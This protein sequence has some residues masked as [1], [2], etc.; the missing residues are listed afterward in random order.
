METLFTGQNHIKIAQCDSVNTYAIDLI[1]NLELPEGTLISAN[2]QSNGKGQGTNKWYSEPGMNVTSSIIYKPKF[3]ELEN[4]FLL[5]MTVSLGLHDLVTCLLD[6]KHDIK[7]K[8]PNDI[9]VNDKKISGILIENLIRADSVIN[10]VI[11]IG[12]NVNQI[13][14]HKEVNNATSIKLLTN[15]NFSI[16][17]ILGRLC[18]SIEKWY[19]RLK[20][21]DR[22]ELKNEYLSRLYLLNTENV[23][24][25]KHGKFFEGI[26]KD[27]GYDGKIH[28]KVKENILKFG[29][30][31]LIF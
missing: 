4:F 14:F 27:V 31:E 18:T 15:I 26:I 28:V 1:K 10:S 19:L 6:S 11:G 23:F 25:D 13:N 2:I 3:I 24:Y 29:N 16:D 30:K 12:L 17:E 8:W 21:G 22:I 7:I 20:Y 5:S 9:L